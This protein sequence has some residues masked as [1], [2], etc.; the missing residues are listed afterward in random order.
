[1]ATEAAAVAGVRPRIL[2]VEDDARLA[3]LIV[4]QLGHG[5]YRAEAVGLGRDALA[6]V[7]AEPFDLV[8]LDLNLPDIDG[9]EVAE[10]LRDGSD[11]PILMLT[12][13]ADVDSR[14]AGLYAG[15]SDYLAKPFS[16]QELL[17]RV[18]VRLRERNAAGIVRFE[19][20]E[21]DP[22][23]MTCRCG[24]E[25]V[26]LPQ[27]E[28]ELLSLLLRH[29]GRLFSREDIERALYGADVPESNTVEVFVY[30]LRRKLGK[31]GRKDLI[32]T[33]RNRG[34]MVL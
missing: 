5:G 11:A 28:F 1:M 25:V 14:V 13:R 26:V 27:R 29:Q 32:R 30:N 19:D 15:A 20:L 9:L 17:A 24:G 16:V 33:V 23:A 21:L 8:L 3:G 2:V 22:D 34:Y 18:H 12:A 6:R 4:E 7:D 31:A 10:R